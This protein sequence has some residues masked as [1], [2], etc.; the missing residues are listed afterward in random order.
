LHFIRDLFVV[1]CALE[2]WCEQEDL[3]LRIDQHKEYWTYHP[4]WDLIT[5]VEPLSGPPDV[6]HPGLILGGHT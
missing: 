5:R 4:F 1:F 2:S 3:G 6:Y